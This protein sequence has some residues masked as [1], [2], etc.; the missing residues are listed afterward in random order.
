M[1]DRQV[2]GHLLYFGVHGPEEARVYAVGRTG[3]AGMLSLVI[4]RN[5]S[6]VNIV[7]GDYRLVYL[8]GSRPRV[9]STPE[10]DTRLYLDGG[11]CLSTSIKTMAHVGHVNAWQCIVTSNGSAMRALVGAA[12]ISQIVEWPAPLLDTPPMSLGA[13]VDCELWPELRDNV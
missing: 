6:P 10:P 1:S 2:I 4:D 7:I 11:V 9:A 12:N 13:D 3:G 5:R 8:V